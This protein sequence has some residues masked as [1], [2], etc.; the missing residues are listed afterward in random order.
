MEFKHWPNGWRTSQY[1]LM[2]NK[3]SL[4]ADKKTR[5]SEYLSSGPIPIVDQGD[6]YIGGYTDDISRIVSCNLPVVV[7]GDH[8]KSV[9]YLPFNFAAGADG[10]KVLQPQKDISAKFLYYQTLYLSI[11]MVNKGYARHYQYLEKELFKYP[12]LPEQE[13]IVA[14][15]EELFSELDNG[16]ET[17]QK[18]KAQLKVYRQSVL[19]D[20]FEGKLSNSESL[21]NG[22]LSDFIERP[23]YGT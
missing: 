10:I 16:V 2:V 13:R 3:V 14:K 7:F 20:A 1:K 8:T 17:L 12:P 9:K 4:P 11:K 21:G 18:T 6:K 22:F 19:K 5:Q 23:R 15:I